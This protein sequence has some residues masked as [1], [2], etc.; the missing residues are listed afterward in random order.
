MSNVYISTK[1]QLSKCD[2]HFVFKDYLGKSVS[3]LPLNTDKI[4]L[5]NTVSITGEAFYLLSKF[6]I[7]VSIRTSGNNEIIS[8]QYPSEKNVFLKQ[9]QY[10][11]LEDEERKLQIAKTIVLGKIKNQLAFIQRIKR[12]AADK[13][14]ISDS[15]I[16][17]KQIPKKVEKCESLESLRGLEGMTARFYFSILGLHI[18]PDWAIFEKRSKHP[19]ETN[20]NAVLS[21]LYFL[22]SGEVE[23]AIQ[24]EG[25]DCMVG[26]LHE[27]QYGRQSLVY[28]L[29]EEFRV[30]F[31]DIICCRLFNHKILNQKDFIK[32]QKVVYLTR[33]GMK[34]V[35]AEFESKMNQTIQINEIEHTCRDAIFKQVEAYK[36]VL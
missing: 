4:I 34:K 36:N 24:S 5:C 3:I 33:E 6:R 27:L 17:I 22:L 15:V 10:K 32:E 26:N 21:Y 29:M 11:M 30:P 16:K 25:L 2:E 1:G 19:P 18:K 13:T 20:V 31:A 14:K 9:L 28:D 23:I 8:I 7:P 12:N 35:V